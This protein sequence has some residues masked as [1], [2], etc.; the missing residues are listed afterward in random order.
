MAA[1]SQV[2]MLSMVCI[3]VMHINYRRSSAWFAFTAAKRLFRSL[4][5]DPLAFDKLHVACIVPT[6][7]IAF[8]AISSRALRRGVW[9]CQLSSSLLLYNMAAKQENL[10]ALFQ[11]LFAL[12]FMHP[13]RQLHKN[14]KTSSSEKKLHTRA[15][16]TL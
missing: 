15:I 14:G 11:F 7:S 4:Q 1:F 3:I 8:A 16:G 13:F 12:H 5:T 2:C 9:W 10:R 6:S